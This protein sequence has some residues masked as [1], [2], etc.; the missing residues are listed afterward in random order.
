MKILTVDLISRMSIDELIEL[1]KQGYRLDEKPS[2]YPNID[3]IVPHSRSGY[4][5]A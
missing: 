4:N 3:D 5:F 1:Y 2:L